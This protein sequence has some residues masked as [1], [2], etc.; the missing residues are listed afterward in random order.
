MDIIRKGISEG[1]SLTTLTMSPLPR[2]SDGQDRHRWAGTGQNTRLAAKDLPCA[3]GAIGGGAC[4]RLRESTA[5]SRPRRGLLRPANLCTCTS[6]P[7]VRWAPCSRASTSGRRRIWCYC[8]SLSLV[9][10]LPLNL[11]ILNL[12]LLFLYLLL[13]TSQR[14]LQL[15]A[16]TSWQLWGCLKIWCCWA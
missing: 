5:A 15:A 4:I 7:A 13:R 11:F 3:A 2:R 12:P 16:G 14:S 6:T 1:G 10:L 9:L 8:E